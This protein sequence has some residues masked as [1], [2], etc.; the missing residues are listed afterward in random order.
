VSD[1]CGV[2]NF[3]VMD[4]A[5]PAHGTWRRLSAQA[6]EADIRVM[7]ETGMLLVL[8]AGVGLLAVF[9]I[10]RR[11]KIKCLT[12][13]RREAE[14]LSNGTQPRMGARTLA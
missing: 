14:N 12:L 8:V 2:T 5:N 9:N 13:E 7:P 4:R 10:S 6:N 1:I 3:G 11:E